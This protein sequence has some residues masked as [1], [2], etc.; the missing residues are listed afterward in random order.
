[1][2]KVDELEKIIKKKIDIYLCRG[3]IYLAI[4]IGDLIKQCLEEQYKAYNE[5]ILNNSGL[6]IREMKY[7]INM[8]FNNRRTERNIFIKAHGVKYVKWFDDTWIN[9]NKH[10]TFIK[11]NR[12]LLNKR[13]ALVWCYVLQKIHK[14]ESIHMPRIT[15]I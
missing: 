12:D 4:E 2:S 8:T 15:V 13:I 1:M 14:E 9:L 3:D 10:T 7:K 6:I 5:Y 11:N